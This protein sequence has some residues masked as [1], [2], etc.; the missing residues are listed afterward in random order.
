MALIMPDAE[1]SIAGA[2]QMA[3][4]ALY[5]AKEDGRN[6]V[7]VDESGNSEIQTGAFRAAGGSAA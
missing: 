1:R 5:R 3:D 2:V 4:E 6:R 7:V